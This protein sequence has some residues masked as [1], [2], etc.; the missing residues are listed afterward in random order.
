MEGLPREVVESPG[1]ILKKTGR[2]TQG[3]G[4]VDEVVLGHR[5]DSDDLRGL[6]QPNRFC[7]SVPPTGTEGSAARHVERCVLYAEAGH[8]KWQ[9][10]T[11]NGTSGRSGHFGLW[12]AKR[13]SLCKAWAPLDLLCCR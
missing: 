6:F 12:C 3:Q 7:G 1:G 13:L 9:V 10:V 8:L 5:L 2:G 11:L 4:L